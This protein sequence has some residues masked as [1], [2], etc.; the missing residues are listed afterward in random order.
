[1]SW[2]NGIMVATKGMLSTK[3]EAMA[4]SHKISIAVGI[5][6]P[7]VISS[8]HLATASITP[9][10]SSPPTS[11]KRPIKKKITG[12]STAC[13]TCSGSSLAIRSSRLAPD[14]AMTEDSRWTYWCRMKPS[15]VRQSTNKHL[16]RS[17]WSLISSCSF[18]VMM[19]FCISGFVTICFR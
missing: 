14:R 5:I 6:L 16:R 19:F 10:S 11:T 1:M 8:A 18:N 15:T 9:T 3:A 2:I 17:A 13:R 12:H 7:P 4:D